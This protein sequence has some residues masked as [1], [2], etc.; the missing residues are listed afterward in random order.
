MESA[1]YKVNENS[2]I[3]FHKMVAKT[4]NLWKHPFVLLMHKILILFYFGWVLFHTNNVKVI[5]PLSS[6]TGGGR[7]QVPLCSLFQA[8]ADTQ[9]EPPHCAS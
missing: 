8:R 9:V 3:V 2:F 4:P 7:P 5:W 6:L 1:N